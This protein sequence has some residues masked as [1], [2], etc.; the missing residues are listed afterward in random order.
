MEPTNPTTTQGRR[1][2]ATVIAGDVLDAIESVRRHAVKV[3]GLSVSGAGRTRSAK[4]LLREVELIVGA[5]VDVDDA[6]VVLTSYGISPAK[7]L[8]SAWAES[9]G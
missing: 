1:V 9:L 8:G 5:D 6:W 3:E 2:W 4:H 7:D